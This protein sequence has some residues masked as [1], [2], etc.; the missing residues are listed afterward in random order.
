VGKCPR[1]LAPYFNVRYWAKTVIQ[2]ICRKGPQR[3][4][5]S[6]CD[7]VLRACSEGNAAKSKNFM[8]SRNG[9][10][11]HWWKRSMDQASN[12]R[13]AGRSERAQR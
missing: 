8:L 5:P 10:T 1:L 4:Q 12:L 3:A 9:P 13:V 7:F 2:S 11:D 6:H